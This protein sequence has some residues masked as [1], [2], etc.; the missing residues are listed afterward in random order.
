MLYR[1]A[2]CER[3]CARANSE[4]SEYQLRLDEAR[5]ITGLAYDG[6]PKGTD[7]SNPTERKA[8]AAMQLEDTYSEHI[9]YLA[10][11][12]ARD[13]LI[14]REVDKVLRSLPPSYTEMAT[15]R[16]VK[17]WTWV[18]VSQNMYMTEQRLRQMDAELV[19][20]IEKTSVF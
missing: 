11:Q 17:G 7:V 12:I 6:M 3:S 19:A 20:R 10:E 1:W 13:L 5:D 18:K 4:I 9:E 8:L 15:N 16:Y 14:R 2:N